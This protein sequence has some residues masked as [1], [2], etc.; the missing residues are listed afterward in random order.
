MNQMSMIARYILGL[1]VALAWGI[2]CFGLEKGIRSGLI[3][4]ACVIIA[5][6]LFPD[7]KSDRKTKE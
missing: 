3:S 4:F 2:L 5:R 1:V 7:Q 6:L